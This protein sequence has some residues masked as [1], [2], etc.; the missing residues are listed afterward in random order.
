MRAL[1]VPLLA[2]LI[3]PAHASGNEAPVITLQVGDEEAGLGIMPRCDDLAV[4]AITPDGRGLK[5][6]KV[7]TTICSFDRS[8]GGGARQVYR[9]VVV[10]RKPKPEPAEGAEGKADRR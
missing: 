7:G 3:F 1:T 9:V 6:L 10:P 4:V 2:V 8:G 5:G